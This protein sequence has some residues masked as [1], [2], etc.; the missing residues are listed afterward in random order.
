MKSFLNFLNESTATQQAA[1]LGLD[2]DGHGGWYKNGE[3]V[4]K[5]EGGKLKFYNKRQRVG[6]DPPQTDKEKNLS[7][8]STDKGQEPESP[9]APKSAP[10]PESIPGSQ[11][12]PGPESPPAPAKA[13]EEPARLPREGPPDVPKTKGT[14]TVAFGR[15]NPPHAGH[16]KLI[17][18]AAESAE[19]DGSDY[20]IIPSRSVRPKTDPMDA[21]SKVEIMR[22]LF[23][24]HSERIVNDPNIRTIFDVLKKAHNDGYAG[25]RIVGGSDRTEAYDRLSTDY[26]GKLYQFDTLE[27]INAGERDADSE[28][29]EGFSASRMRLAAQENDFKAFYNQL[30]NEVEI[31]DENGEFIIDEKTGEPVMEMIPIME[32]KPAKEY[33]TKVR[34]ALKLEEGWSLWQ[35]APKLDWKNLRENYVKQNIFNIGQLVENFNTGLVGRILRRG[36]NYLICVTEDN[37][38]FKSWIRDVVETTKAQSQPMVNVPSKDRNAI[39]ARGKN[40][41]KR[42]LKGTVVGVNEEVVNGTTKSGVP[43]DQR[44]VGTD[45]HRKYVETMVPGSQW[46]RH[47]INKYRKKVSQ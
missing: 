19:S 40:T 29:M 13:E 3:F 21:D 26:N 36:T 6:Q 24:E 16:G 27:T 12:A 31:V 2:G 38:M 8:T 9:P 1:R 4:A 14:L 37:I 28:G 25:V 45:A 34:Q 43:S 18:V 5:T 46:G 15:F 41:F 44:L 35:I 42:D 10:G 47:F 39:K 11:P 23:P 33:F 32:K 7:H 17:G 20:M 30:H 22:S